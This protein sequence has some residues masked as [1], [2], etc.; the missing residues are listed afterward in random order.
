MT[1]LMTMQILII[2][3]SLYHL[4]FRDSDSITIKKL[5]LSHNNNNII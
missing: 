5:V 2:S 3:Y 1:N 4:E